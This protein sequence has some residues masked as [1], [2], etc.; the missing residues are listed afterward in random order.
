[1]KV[2]ALIPARKGSKEVP[3]KNFKEF[4]GKPL[5]YWT[6]DTAVESGV[7]DSIIVSTDGVQAPSVES[8]VI[9]DDERPEELATDEASLDD[10]L[11]Y[12]MF[13]YPE[14]DM[15]CLLQPT[16]PLRTAGDIKNAYYMMFEKEADGEDYKYDSLVSVKSH[17]VLAWVANAVGI[18]DVDDPQPIATYPVRKRPNRQDRKDWYLENGAIYFTRKYVLDQIKCRLHGYIGLY[19]MP[20]ERSIE[21]DSPMDWK[22]AEFLG[23]V[24]GLA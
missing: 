22:M 9:W 8:N 7:F 20:E 11:C 24:N 2:A 13:K 3:Y 23:G 5:V 15:W 12:Y 1:M 17:P 18:P 16:S 14:I 21:I 4:L 6:L 19:V 10:L